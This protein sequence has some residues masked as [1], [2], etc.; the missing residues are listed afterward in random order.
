MTI[1]HLMSFIGLCLMIT[2]TPGLDTAAVVRNTLMSTRS[3]GM[4]TALGCAA[5]LFVHA[6]LVALGLAELLLRSAI[7]FEFVKFAGAMVLVGLGA[8]SLWR[9]WRIGV[10]NN[11]LTTLPRS[12]RSSMPFLQGLLTNLTNPKA[13]LFFLAALPQFLPSGAPSAAV[14]VALGLAVIA[15]A[16]SLT[17]LG[18]TVLGVHQIRHLLRSRRARRIQDALLGATLIALGVRVAVE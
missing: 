17:G 18:L 16:F 15:V 4:L 3:A 14:P 6:T 2:I 9:A 13:A 1:A 10:G 7:L 5:G 8:R 11:V 12:K